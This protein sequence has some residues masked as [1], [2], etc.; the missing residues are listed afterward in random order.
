MSFPSRR[1]LP[2]VFLAAIAFAQ[3]P[4]K[5]DDAALRNA[6]KSGDEWLTYGLDQGETR[7]SPLNQIDASNVSRLAPAWS[8]DLGIGGGNQE[9]TPLV[10]N[11]TIYGITNW[12]VVFAVDARTGKE[13]WKWD[14]EVNQP[15]TRAK[16]CC[17]VVNRGIAVYNGKIIAPVID[18]RLVALD[19]FTGKPVW[20]AA[21]RTRRITTR[22]PW[23]PALRKAK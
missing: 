18:G 17:G 13:K 12:S 9:A 7:Y 23:R 21:F 16:I 15:A 10:W 6:G 2:A 1:Y 11:G 5:I 14:P 20:E 4:H 8:Y 22:S 19:A 3:Q